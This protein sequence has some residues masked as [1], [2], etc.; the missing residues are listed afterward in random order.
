MTAQAL[1]IIRIVMSVIE[2]SGENQ[3]AIY[4]T[5]FD[6]LF[7]FFK[8]SD[9][10]NKTGINFFNTGKYAEAILCFNKSLTLNP[11]NSKGW[12]NKGL[13]LKKIG[14]YEEA[15]FCYDQALGIN[16]NFLGALNSKANL[17]SLCGLYQKARE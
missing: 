7:L 3:M 5:I 17:L 12:Y 15:L 16:P 9:N 13:V 4:D 8:N 2:F 11:G 1:S 6:Q 14:N 10:L